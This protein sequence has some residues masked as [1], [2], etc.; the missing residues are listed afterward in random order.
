MAP[1]LQMHAIAQAASAGLVECL[2]DGTLVAIFAGVLLRLLRGQNSAL[3]FALWFA[4]LTAI[5]ALPF[6]HYAASASG[7]V[8]QHPIAPAIVLPSSWATY[9]FVAWMLLVLFC[10]LR[11]VIAFQHVRVLRKS[12]EPIAPN[13]IGPI[14]QL[15][16]AGYRTG[17]AVSLCTSDRVQVPMA[18]GLFKP[19][20]VIPRWILDELSPHE[21]HQVLL[22]ELAHLRRWDDWTNLAQKLMKAV[23]F[24]HPAVW[25]IE[26]QVS[27]EREMACDDAVVAET[28]RARD[29]AECLARIAEKTLVRRTLALAQA[30]LGKVRQTSLRFAQILDTKRPRQ[31]RHAWRFAVPATALLA[32]CCA[33]LIAKTPTV[34]A[35][36]DSAPA[37]GSR[38][39]MASSSSPATLQPILASLKLPETAARNV[40]ETA[41]H[42][43]VPHRRVPHPAPSA[44]SETVAAAIQPGST[45]MLGTE[46]IS[47]DTMLQPTL[48]HFTGDDES[49]SADAVVVVVQ[50]VPQNLSSEPIYE[51]QVW[52]L[53]VLHP[54]QAVS[55]KAPNKQI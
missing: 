27:L 52:H 2:I 46:W 6:W 18:I 28:A 49:A 10:L 5:S 1:I 8:V 40:P 14:S 51:I 13:K 53:T 20:V 29:Y 12:C 37:V 55:K 9:L 42:N 21:L 15:A 26:R 38:A 4:S 25:W 35:F 45:T 43:Q 44:A 32:T 16:V 33:L 22:H 48:I 30:A 47:Q 23:F 39:I 7:A 36:R 24:F 31:A 11:L 19:L 50:E 54:T 3:R 17:R 34:V 41:A